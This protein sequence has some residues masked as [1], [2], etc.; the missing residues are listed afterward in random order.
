MRK[1]I[2]ILAL[3]ILV[4][5]CTNQAP[6]NPDCN[7]FSAD[8][9]PG[10]C[11]VCPPC[12]ACSSVSCQTEEF[13][14]DLGFDRDWHSRVSHP[15]ANDT[16]DIT[17]W[18]DLYVDPP[19]IHD[20]GIDLEPYDPSTGFAGDVD[21]GGLTYDDRAFITFG[22]DLD[23]SPNVHPT[24]IIPLG[25]EIR[26]VSEGVVHRIETLGDDDYDIC[27]HRGEGDEWCISYEHATNIRVSEGDAV[28][29]G[30]V[31]GEAGRINEFTDS[32]KFD[33]KVW[34]GGTTTILNHCPYDLFDPSVM[35]E[36]Q[37]ELS[38]FIRDWEEFI[39]K[40]VY[41]ED[42]WLSPGCITETLEEHPPG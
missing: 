1:G 10:Y 28:K 37:A 24:F 7:S 12:E 21:F 42:S 23:G 13:C 16:E 34:R 14:L 40:D 8:D 26:S 29:V 15:P 41:D 2:L 3:V 38:R 20:M 5:G 22:G 6:E 31:L 35:E 27:V 30:D 18:E 33:L 36:K 19:V 11:V 39:G 9:C 4:S 25:T 17:E 32:G